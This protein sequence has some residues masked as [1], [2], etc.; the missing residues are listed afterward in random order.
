MVGS[1]TIRCAYDIDFAFNRRVESACNSMFDIREE[2]I[3]GIRVNNYFDDIIEQY[4]AIC[5][6][7]G[8]MVLLNDK[9]L[10]LEVREKVMAKNEEIPYLYEL[11][12]VMSEF[13]H[14][15]YQSN[16]TKKKVRTL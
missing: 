3:Y 10:S 6:I 4:Y 7:C 1:M 2:D 8:H 9:S 5:P 13:I 11:N 15:K 16:K 12:N 14:L